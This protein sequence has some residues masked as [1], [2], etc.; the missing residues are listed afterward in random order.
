M[1]TDTEQIRYK[2]WLNQ[3]NVIS[4]EEIFVSIEDLPD[5]IW[6]DAFKSGL[7]PSEAFWDY[8]DEVLVE[9]VELCE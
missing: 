7:T 8:Y 1:A 3:V 9:E 2:T 4:N 6:L 5:W